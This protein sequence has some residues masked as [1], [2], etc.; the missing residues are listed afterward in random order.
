MALDLCFWDKACIKRRE[1]AQALAQGQIAQQQQVLMGIANQPTG[2]L[3]AWA[4]T[5]IV[6]ATLGIA[7]FVV[8]KIKNRKK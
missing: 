2:G 3:N 7:A 6:A 4:I 8:Y 1:E 5:A